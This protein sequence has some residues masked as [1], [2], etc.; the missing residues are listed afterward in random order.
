MRFTVI[1]TSAFTIRSAEGILDSG[2]E[3]AA[4]ISLCNELLPDNSADLLS[5]STARGMSYY[6]VEDINS[7]HSSDII[8]GSRPDYIFSSWPKIIQRHILSIPKYYCIGTHPTE[9]PYNR[10]RHPLH[11]CISMGIRHTEL[12]FFLIDEGVDTGNVLLKI[13]FTID[14]EEHIVSAVAKMNEAGYKGA[15]ALCNKLQREPN[16]LGTEQ[17]HEVANYWRSRTLHDVTLD[18]RMSV[19]MIVRTVR[20]FSPPYPCANLIFRRHVIKIVQ[21]RSIERGH[22]LSVI[23]RMEPGRI[24]DVSD[25]VLIVKAED[26]LVELRCKNK[27]PPSVFKATYI[28]PPAK[29]LAEWSDVLIPQLS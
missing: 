17:D 13:P 12:S 14:A 21:A 16:F 7:D 9:L 19:D 23:L 20:S 4:V 10:G 11:W 25:K 24:L 15:F 2:N 29:Y 26:G 8:N 5:F 22:S 28:F 1:G 27:L 3:I 18:M 6:E